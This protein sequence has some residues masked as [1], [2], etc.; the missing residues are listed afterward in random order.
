[1]N[2][3]VPV[4]FARP[5]AAAVGACA[6]LL[7]AGCHSNSSDGSSASSGTTGS[8]ASGGGGGQTLLAFVTNNPSDYWKICNKGVDAAAAKLGDKVQ[9][10]E[11]ADGSVQTQKQDVDDLLAKGVKGIAISPVDPANETDYLNT[12]AGKT[13]LITSDS[14]APNSSRLCYIGTD[15]HA[16]GVMAGALI[17]KSIP[18][19]GKIML[20]VGKSDAQNAR[21]RISGIQDAL[22]GSNITI[23]DTRTD[24]T[25]HARAK[26]NA[27]DAIV[28]NPDL[29]GMVGIWSYNGPAIYS[30]VKGAGKQGKI[31]IIAFDQ[32]EDTMNGIKD[33]TIAGTI[34][35]QPYQFGYESV[36]ML[37]KL[38]KGDK[39][40]IPANKLMIIPTQVI[41]KANIAAYEA[42]QAKLMGGA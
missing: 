2:T 42:S 39:S 20:F 16:A 15:N 41:N 12:V 40:G 19:G 32:E 1:M 28:S 9:F 5:L 27:A 4:R 3:A 18:Q 10:V 11:P 22:K 36:M 8:G 29:V 30:A 34:V 25:D 21:D 24:D 31:Q 23:A 33:G 35:Q 17:K 26:Q 14:D 37:D 6:L 13:N 38:A 7:L